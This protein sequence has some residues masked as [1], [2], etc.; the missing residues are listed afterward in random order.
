MINIFLSNIIK[1]YIIMDTVGIYH[2][3][4]L[5]YKNIH[6]GEVCYLFGAG[7]T[8]NNFKKQENGIYIGVNHTLQKKEIR[9][10]LKYYFFGH[11]YHYLTREEKKLCSGHKEMVDALNH[12]IVE[13]FCMVSL[14]NKFI[15][16]HKFTPERVEALSKINAIPCDMNLHAFYTDIHN[17]SFMNH[18]II[19]PA[20]QFALYAGFTK[21]YL[22]GCDCTG[23]FHSKGFSHKN[24]NKTINGA[25]AMDEKV[26][27]PGGHFKG[28]WEKLYKHKNKH[29]PNVKIININPVGL[30]NKMDK[31]IFT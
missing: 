5:K 7:P 17:N 27:G 8:L 3:K 24:G 13:K 15:P 31:D 4:L 10:N 2:K 1:K 11:G 26:V 20:V 29:Y 25:L 22:V 18:S 16:Q 30:K 23:S 9:D 12:N 6:K 14:N 19:F 28:W 21:I